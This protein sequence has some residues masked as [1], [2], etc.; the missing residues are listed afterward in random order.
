VAQWA[1]AA[2]DFD[3]IW[4]GCPWSSRRPGARWP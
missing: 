4:R 2:E 1:K 3:E